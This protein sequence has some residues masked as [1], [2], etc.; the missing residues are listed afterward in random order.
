MTRSLIWSGNAVAF[1]V[2]GMLS[3]YLSNPDYAVVGAI[4]GVVV[5]I[6]VAAFSLTGERSGG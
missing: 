3:C 1:S 6:G 5:G 4:G 2:I